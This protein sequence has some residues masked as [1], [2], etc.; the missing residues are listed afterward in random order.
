MENFSSCQHTTLIKIIQMVSTDI[1]FDSY[2]DIAFVTSLFNN[3]F[4]E[5]ENR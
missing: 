1:V 4:I 5:L 3:V 2:S